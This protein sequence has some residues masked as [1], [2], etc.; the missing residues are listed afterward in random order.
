MDMNN[1]LRIYCPYIRYPVYIKTGVVAFIV[2]NKMKNSL[3]QN[4]QCQILH[5]YLH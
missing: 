1:H 3:W 4:K 5:P 2:Y